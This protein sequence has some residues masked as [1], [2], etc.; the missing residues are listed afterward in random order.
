MNKSSPG[1][2]AR[3]RHQCVWLCYSAHV[4]HLQ[5]PSW[6]P[7]IPAPLS[8]ISVVPHLCLSFP[9]KVLWVL[10]QWVPS[11]EGSGPFNVGTQ[12]ASL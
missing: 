11:R 1:T 8:A 2:R 5:V 6:L 12:K 10:A 9:T 7:F 3:D 4:R